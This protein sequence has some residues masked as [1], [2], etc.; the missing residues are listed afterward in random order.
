MSS[1]TII[2]AVLVIFVVWY[3]LRRTTLGKAFSADVAAIPQQFG[4]AEGLKSGQTHVVE[5]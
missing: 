5:V 1:N 3:L 4:V 2:K